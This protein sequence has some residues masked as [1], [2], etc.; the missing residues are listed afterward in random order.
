MNSVGA[1]AVKVDS[2]VAAHPL[3]A[4]LAAA[5]GLLHCKIEMEYF[6]SSVIAGKEDQ[7]PLS[8][9][10]FRVPPT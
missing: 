3:G 1:E 7:V 10:I 8:T 6:D 2:G 9:E 5:L 4:A